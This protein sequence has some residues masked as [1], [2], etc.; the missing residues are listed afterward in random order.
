MKCKGRR[1]LQGGQLSAKDAVSQ[2]CLCK[3]RLYLC[4]KP[5]AVTDR[6]G[7][8]EQVWLPHGGCRSSLS[9][10]AGVAMTRER[11]D[12]LLSRHPPQAAHHLTPSVHQQC[13]AEKALQPPAAQVSRAGEPGGDNH[14][15][16][17]PG[18][19]WK[20]CVSVRVRHTCPREGRCVHT[21][22]FTVA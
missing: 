5:S 2:W 21:S 20:T 9:G 13:L 15:L 17:L 8:G 7:K 11:V 1:Q 19:L 10:R 3:E 12:H 16:S 18:G 6:W 14:T 4:I 22:P